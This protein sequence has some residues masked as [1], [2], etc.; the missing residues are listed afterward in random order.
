MKYNGNA[1][2]R[3][4]TGRNLSHPGGRRFVETRRNPAEKRTPAKDATHGGTLVE[5]EMPAHHPERMTRNGAPAS[6]LMAG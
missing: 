2:A 5:S 4:R 1:T 6:G 3:K